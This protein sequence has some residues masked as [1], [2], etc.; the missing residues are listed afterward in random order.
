LRCADVEVAGGAYRLIVAFDF[1][2]QAA[3]IKFIAT[4]AEYDAIDAFTVSRIP[5]RARCKSLSFAPRK[6]TSSPSP[7]SGPCGGAELNSEEGDRLE[8]LLAL[9]DNYE[10]KRWPIG[11]GTSLDPIDI[12][13]FAIDELGHT[14]AELSAL[15]GSRSGRRSSSRRRWR[16]A[17]PGAD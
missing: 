8:A 16:W 4:H 12:L 7:K 9:V 15:L 6:I 14:R 11:A 3:F 2:R 1:R 17:K 10:P 5:R 13:R